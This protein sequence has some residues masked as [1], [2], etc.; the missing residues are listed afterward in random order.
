MLGNT[1]SYKVDDAANT[2]NEHSNEH[3]EFWIMWGHYGTFILAFLVI[4]I[5]LN[6]IL[7]GISV[8]IAKE[9]IC[10]ANF[11]RMNAMAHNLCWIDIAKEKI[12]FFLNQGKLNTLGSYFSVTNLESIQ[13]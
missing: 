7:I 10:Q 9:G 8:N 6:N 11:H 5:A 1:Y 12:E 13:K 4:T 2:I 3:F